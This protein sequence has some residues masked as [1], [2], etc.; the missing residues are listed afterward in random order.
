MPASKAQQKAV[1]KYMQ[2]NYDEIK[3]RVPK[4]KRDVI[5]A[6]AQQQGQSTNAYIT[7][8]IDERMEREQEPSTPDGEAEAPP[9]ENGSAE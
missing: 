8:A 9:S 6:H 7:Q 5:Q 4:G 3:V 2:A 1:K